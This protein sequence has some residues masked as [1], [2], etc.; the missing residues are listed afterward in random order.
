LLRNFELQLLQEIGYALN[1]ERDAVVHEPL[2]PEQYYE[3]VIEHGAVRVD[4]NATGDAIFSGAS[5]LAIGRSD[6]E[7]E[8]D[9]RNA[10]KLLRT[11]LNYHLG[12]RSLHTRRVAS[13]M[14][15]SG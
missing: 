7:N 3:F 4:D 12:G 6:F 13:A 9:L 14:K 15:R 11:V 2:N 1:L 8:D 10:K 5:L